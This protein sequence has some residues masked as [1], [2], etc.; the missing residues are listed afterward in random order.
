MKFVLLAVLLLAAGAARATTIDTF[1]FTQ[2]GYVAPNA[3][4]GTLSGTFTGKVESNGTIA[5][6][7]LSSIDVTFSEPIPG[8][9]TLFVFG[10]GPAE[11][12]SFS[13][14]GG[15]SSLDLETRIGTDGVACVGAV[16]AFGFG[17]C[18]TGGLSG[19]VAGFVTGLAYTADQAVVTLVSSISISPPPP[20]LVPPVTPQQTAVPEPAAAAVFAAALLSL[21][22]LRRQTLNRNSSTSPSLTTYS[23]PSTRILPASFAPASP[24]KVEKSS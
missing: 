19:P 12:F 15:A 6:A 17:G 10:Y 7:D 13:T 24:R 23:L 2:G 16:A 11:F 4:I 21:A 9:G 18:D 14:T 3:G 5:L 1:S 8:V 20:P 22:L